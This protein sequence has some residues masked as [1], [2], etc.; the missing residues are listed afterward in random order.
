MSA[1]NPE[2]N[3]HVPHTPAR[4]A[5]D[6]LWK[7]YLPAGA[8]TLMDGDPEA[9]KSFLSVDLAA[10]L[11]AGLPLPDGQPATAPRNVLFVN[12]EDPIDTVV[13]PRYEAAGGDPDRFRHYGGLMT[14]DA[15]SVTALLTRDWQTFAKAVRDRPGGLVILD[16]ISALFPPSVPI[17]CDQV[18]RQWFTGL[19]RLAAETGSAI[20]ILRHLIKV[21][22]RRALYRGTG[23]IGIAGA[24]RSVLLVGR[25]PDDPT[26]RILTHPKSNLAPAGAAL[27]FHI[28]DTEPPTLTWDGPTNLTADD[29]CRATAGDGA[30]KRAERWL[31]D[32]LAAGPVRSAKIEELA[33]QEGISFT[34]LRL[35]KK[36]IGAESHRV[37]EG[38]E[39]YWVWEQPTLD[40]F[41]LP[42]LE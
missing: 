5:L 19:A 25:H 41:N 1:A 13:L 7:P 36:R 39:A 18:I 9:G 8:L 11:S 15:R 30:S 38:T 42:P 31:K 27:A 33:H 4:P 24:A 21:L 29:L 26:R 40:P 20:L 22:A 34:T 32:L 10:R 16:P 2:T 6:W 14:G 23:S 3:G 12:A 17:N 28:A 35:A 37:Q